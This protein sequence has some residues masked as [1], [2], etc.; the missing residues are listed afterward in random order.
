MRIPDFT[1]LNQGGGSL[2]TLETTPR[3]KNPYFSPIHRQFMLKNRT[4]ASTPPSNGQ[5]MGLKMHGDFSSMAEVASSQELGPMQPKLTEKI[6]LDFEPKED[7]IFCEKADTDNSA[8]RI[9]LDEEETSDNPIVH[10]CNCT[11]TM[12]NV[13]LNCF[14][15]WI[16]KQVTQKKSSH[17]LSMA[18]KNLHCELCK[19]DC[20]RKSHRSVISF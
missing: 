3:T 18:W 17:L 11:G 5:K 12:K 10:P 4:G 2:Q 20:D 13:H 1:E 14:R 15:E 16:T 9:C 19:T 6:S 7:L 8:C